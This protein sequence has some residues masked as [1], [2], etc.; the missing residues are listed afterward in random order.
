M[1]RLV[2]FRLFKR[3]LKRAY[4]YGNLLCSSFAALPQLRR[5]LRSPRY[6][7]QVPLI[8]LVLCFAE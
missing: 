5:Y 8:S 4:F 3:I 1:K 6:Y 2:A 7:V